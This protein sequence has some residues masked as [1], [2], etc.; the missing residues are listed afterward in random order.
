[1]RKS[2]SCRAPGNRVYLQRG[3]FFYVKEIALNSN[4]AFSCLFIS[5]LVMIIAV[6]GIDLGVVQVRNITHLVFDKIIVT[7]LSFRIGPL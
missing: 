4:A 1:M 5:E 3:G 6:V 2:A 7:H